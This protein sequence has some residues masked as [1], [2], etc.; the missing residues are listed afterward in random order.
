MLISE[1][2]LIEIIKG[3][4]LYYAAI[5]DGIDVDEYVKEL[6][7]TIIKNQSKIFVRKEIK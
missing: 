6:A 2:A 4:N 1:E 3:S 5:E 7:Q